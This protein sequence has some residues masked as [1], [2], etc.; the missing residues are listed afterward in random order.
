MQKEEKNTMLKVI[1]ADDERKAR[2]IIR[3][4]GRWTETGLEIV[5]EAEDGDELYRIAAELLPDV[6]ITDMKMPGLYGSELIRSLH[7]L[8]EDMKLIIISGYDEF[9]LAKQALQSKAVDYLLK[10]I[11]EEELNAA[12][13]K[14]AKEIRLEKKKLMENAVLTSKANEAEEHTKVRAL[15]KLVKSGNITREERK[16]C[17]SPYDPSNYE[18]FTVAVLKI[19]RFHWLFARYGADT[20]L[21]HYV[22]INIMNE[23]A[24]RERMAIF[25]NE[26][27][28][29]EIILLAYQSMSTDEW[30][31]LL[32]SFNR[33]LKKFLGI[34]ML[35]GIGN[36]R[37]TIEQIPASLDEARTSILKLTFLKETTSFYGEGTNRKQNILSPIT[38]IPELNTAIEIDDTD[39]IGRVI[40]AMIHQLTDHADCR[41]SD[42]RNLN[43][44]LFTSLEQLSGHTDD[45]YE[46]SLELGQVAQALHEEFDPE[47]VLTLYRQFLTA[48]SSSLA[49]RR[50][51]REKSA[52]YSIR[53]YIEENYMSKLSLDEL[54]SKFYMTGEHI[55]RAFKE[56]FNINLFDYIMRL[57][58]ERAKIFIIQ[59]AMKVSEIVELLGFVDA[60]HFTK[61]FKKHT[62]LTPT[63]YR[64]RAKN[65]KS[66][67]NTRRG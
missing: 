39:E 37:S 38:L 53:N 65:Q 32:E 47:T 4:L 34:K 17:F 18:T 22:L 40:D 57:K 25:R 45:E 30:K 36:P 23:I 15:N 20:H 3:S 21:L 2:N 19:N 11:D 42:L 16:A 59:N 33:N 64:D 54:S 66:Q 52:I 12:L 60:S 41:L 58:I 26:S 61:T 63:E 49:G 35:A 9:E 46:F 56:E 1:I 27:E 13:L 62:G 50:R 10:P 31:S 44:Q 6:V 5:G 14:A 51:K 43:Q 67:L 24:S 8:D 28:K 55:S 48:I 29:N 7:E